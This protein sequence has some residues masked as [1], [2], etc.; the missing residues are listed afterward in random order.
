[1]AARPEIEDKII[2]NV[3]VQSNPTKELEEVINKDTAIVEANEGG[4]K[5]IEADSKAS[6]GE[7]LAEDNG[8]KESEEVNATEEVKANEEAQTAAEEAI[9]ADDNGIDGIKADDEEKD[10]KV[11]TE[12]KES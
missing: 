5:T 2:D 11:T 1:M 8:I 4:P 12:V 10:T 6:E 9:I 7:R 3:E